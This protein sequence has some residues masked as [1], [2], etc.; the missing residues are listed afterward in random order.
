MMIFM[1]FDWWDK[2]GRS[3]CISIIPKWPSTNI[4]LDADGNIDWRKESGTDVD[5]LKKCP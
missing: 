4:Y 3:R 2:S 5:R 1:E